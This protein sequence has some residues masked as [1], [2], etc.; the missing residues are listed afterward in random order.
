MAEC[1]KD[2]TKCKNL[3]GRTEEIISIAEG[4]WQQALNANSYYLII[5]QYND[6]FRD[7]KD[8]ISMSSAFYSVAY[9]AM[10]DALFIELSKLF[11]KTTGVINLRYLL[12]LCEEDKCLPEY[13]ELSDK[14][15]TI[16][17][18]SYIHKI[19]TGEEWYFKEYIEQENKFQKLFESSYTG[20]ISKEMRASE[21][22][23]FLGKQYNSMNGITEKLTQQRNK[24][25][26]H[27]DGKL[28]FNLKECLENNP[29]RFSDIQTLI[30]YAFDVTR[31]VIGALTGIEKAIAYANIN[32]W[33]GTLDYVKLGIKYRDTEIK[34]QTEKYIEENITG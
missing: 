9:Q 2:C 29:L 32:D 4:L 30:D 18:T 1:N 10:Q 6:Y 11:D 34:A 22:I 31:F 3:S 12:K 26:T 16:V 17:N 25:Y 21:Y 15:G 24:I 27:N 33:K 19:K 5:K 13:R 23:D 7:Y 8:E 14:N 20:E 28:K